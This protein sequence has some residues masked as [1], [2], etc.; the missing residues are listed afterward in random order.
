MTEA[1]SSFYL[2]QKSRYRVW[3]AL[4]LVL[5]GIF[6]PGQARASGDIVSGRLANVGEFP[7][8]ALLRYNSSFRCG[9]V[10]VHPDWALTAAH[11]VHISDNV[12]ISAPALTLTF[13]EHDRTQVDDPNRQTRH[14]T[15][16]YAH[17]GYLGFCCDHDL[18]LLHLDQPVSV[19]AR[20]Q[21]IP[22]LTDGTQLTSGT[23]GT[24][25]GWGLTEHNG[26]T[27]AVLRAVD[28]TVTHDSPDYTYFLTSNAG[29]G[30][31]CNGDSGGP[32]VI[33]GSTNGVAG[34]VLAGIT[35]F[36]GCAPGGGFARVSDSLGW[37]TPT[38]TT[39]VVA[40]GKFTFTVYLP[41]M[42]NRLTAST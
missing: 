20:V 9:A 13:G 22:L 3:L 29:T 17:P 16:F 18:A 8:Q 37:I 35:S 28:L 15:H 31:V 32:F 24:A 41:L 39:P 21:P 40:S 25:T 19:N 30:A 5:S 7:W 6:S 14:V 2:R 34:K 33:D 42:T 26:A 1:A 4:L 27:S 11:C 12:L 23:I 36:G 10:L 38:L